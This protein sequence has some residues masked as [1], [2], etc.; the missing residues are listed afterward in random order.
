MPG[1]IVVIIQAAPARQSHAADI[2]LIVV[3]I[4]RGASQRIAAGYQ[5]GVIPDG[6]FFPSQRI[7]TAGDQTVFVVPVP[8]FAAFGI[9]IGGATFFIVIEKAVVTPL[10]NQDVFHQNPGHPPNLQRQK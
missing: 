6:G 5:L 4:F 10:K 3:V 9:Q 7:E 8:G 2:T 1:R